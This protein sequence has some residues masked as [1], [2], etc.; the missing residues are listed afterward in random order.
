MAFANFLYPRGFYI[1]ESSDNYLR[2]VIPQLEKGYGIT[3]GNTLRRI[4]LSSIEGYSVVAVYIEGVVHE[5][6]SMEGVLEDVP[7]ILL[8]IKKIKFKINEE[9]VSFPARVS[10][11][12]EGPGEIR[13][14]FIETQPGIEIINKDQYIATVTT[15]R[16]V[17]ID[18]FIDKGIGFVPSEDYP[19]EYKD[20]FSFGTIFVDG[21]FSPVEKVNW[22]VEKTRYEAHMDK[23]KLI[24]EIWTN[25]TISPLE[26]YQKALNILEKHVS[27]LRNE[28][29]KPIEEF[30]YVD[31]EDFDKRVEEFKKKKITEL[32]LTPRVIELLKSKGIKT[33]SD[34]ISF[35]EEEVNDWFI[36]AG[37]SQIEFED[38]RRKINSF[39]LE[40]SKKGG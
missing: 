38:L 31:V 21:D 20:L 40:F 25:G 33:V 12:F 26:A 32:A 6:S 17:H 9:L 37:L 22:L 2:I 3:L 30:E 19:E 36:E 11:D 28:I 27:I 39:S 24:L 10:L 29:R 8:N 34:L 7:Y 5:F 18:I 13:A 1:D 16:N 15:K 23:D 35:T 4:L 14:E